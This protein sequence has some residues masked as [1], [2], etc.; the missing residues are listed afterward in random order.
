MRIMPKIIRST[1]GLVIVLI[2]I[3]SV[4]QGGLS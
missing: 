1:L 2:A 4:I 3:P